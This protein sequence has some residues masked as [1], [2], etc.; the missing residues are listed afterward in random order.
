[1]WLTRVATHS[2]VL[3]PMLLVVAALLLYLPR[4]ATPPKYLFDE[5]LFAYTAGEYVHGNDDAFRW[6]HPCSATK[7]DKRCAEL[8]PEAVRY[9]RVG[10]YQWGHPPLGK[11]LIGVGIVI[12]GNDPFGWRIVSAV[13]GAIG[14]VIAYYIGVVLT[15]R[16][17]V[18]L[19]TAGMLLLDG[20][21]FVYSRI[22]LLE[23]YVAVFTMATLLAFATYVSA[24]PEQSRGPLLWT[25][26]MMALSI[27]T[28]WSGAYG[29][30]FIGLFILWR[31]LKLFREG[32]IPNPQPE[33]RAALRLHLIW[34][35]VALVVFPVV[36][37][38]VVHV[39]FFLAGN[40][41][42]DFFD[43][44]RAI[45]AFQTNLNDSPRTAS[46]WWQWPLDWRS[47]WFGTRNLADGR[48][49]KT[50]ALG[51][52]FLYWA[53][54]PAVM[55]LTIR[56]RRTRHLM[57]PVLVVGFFGQWL[58]WA[59]V[60]RS[61]YLYHFLPAVPIGCFAVAVAVVHLYDASSGWRRTL[62]VEYVVLVALAFAF[63]YPIYSYY[64]ISNHALELRLWLSSWR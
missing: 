28:K 15:G 4:L 56:W 22:G 41:L 60:G 25:G 45:L 34:A 33:V 5:I 2:R 14:I 37:Y 58:P 47:V 59:L 7:S 10:K 9:N 3:I 17:A 44:Q 48:I 49:A 40:S 54:V 31:M 64:P 23:I 32:R 8:H 39:P 35:P 61:S 36:A 55:W 46:R 30:F 57:L 29:G 19:L 62:A 51:N 21:Y 43:L 63:F 27:S 38:L 26:A 24:R 50:Y 18:G 6:D 12:F 13:F 53:F 16:R 20:M 42:R 1:M 11:H 52:P